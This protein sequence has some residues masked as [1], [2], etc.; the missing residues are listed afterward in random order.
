MLNYL[1]IVV[2]FPLYLALNFPAMA[3]VFNKR[4]IEVATFDLIPTDFISNAAFYLPEMDPFNQKFDLY[5]YGST[6]FVDNMGTSLWMQ[7]CF[8]LLIIIFITL[9]CVKCLRARLG[10]FLI[11]NGLLRLFMESYLESTLLSTLNIHRIDWNTDFTAI[12]VSNILSI[13]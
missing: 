6:I 13:V 3:A 5:D 4:I 7:A 1:Q 9:Y 8:I 12:L 10:A 2:Y 11:W